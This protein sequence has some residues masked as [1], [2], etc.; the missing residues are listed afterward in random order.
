MADDTVK[1]FNGGTAARFFLALGYVD[2]VSSKDLATH[3]FTDRPDGLRP[4]TGEDFLV[5]TR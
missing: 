2:H 1:Q 5:A 4:S 3:R